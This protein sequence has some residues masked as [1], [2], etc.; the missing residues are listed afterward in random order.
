MS[1]FVRPRRQVKRRLAPGPSLR[2]V[3]SLVV[4]VMLIAGVLP[5]SASEEMPTDPG[6]PAGQSESF[7]VMC[8]PTTVEDVV[9]E[10]GDDQPHSTISP[11]GESTAE[12]PRC[13]PFVYEMGYPFAHDAP[14]TSPF[15]AFRDGGS[16]RHHGVD[17]P[18][19]KMT[20]V[21]AVAS[22]VVDWIRDGSGGTVCCSL[23]ITHE[24]EYTSYYVHLNNDTLGTDDGLGFGIVPG[25][26]VGDPVIGGQVIGYVGDSGNAEDTWPHLHFEL[27]LPNGT[28]ID[29]TSSLDAALMAGDEVDDDEMMEGEDGAAE[30]AEVTSGL[31]GMASV[32]FFG[33]FSD[34]DNLPGSLAYDR[35][36]SRGVLDACDD[37]HQSFCPSDRM[38]V[39]PALS[40]IR[41]AL[42]GSEIDA[43]L[44]YGLD[45][46]GIEV[47]VLDQAT[48]IQ[49]LRGC[50]EWRLCEDQPLQVG[51]AL[52]ILANSL[53]LAPG[54]SGR[55]FLD[56]SSPF[57]DAINAMDSAGF[58]Q[59][60]ALIGARS[61]DPE[62]VVTRSWLATQLAAILFPPEGPDCSTM[63]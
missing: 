4:L 38:T 31:L 53:D 41:R 40:W 45:R 20:A 39:S 16:R 24:D 30:P 51:E 5:L 60:C 62:A 9:F 3:G 42:P 43:S 37:L 13:D 23:A 7:G 50:S 63:Q 21:L 34:D 44:D 46:S 47:T 10:E 11:I 25:L 14:V 48:D 6:I 36:A 8:D 29:P 54:R 15:A 32:E 17:I 56:A 61:V 26:S 2:I 49:A 35:L 1:V 52:A 33:A 12:G 57:Y 22:G 27:H 55:F 19:P 28:P 18:S 58:V 59:S